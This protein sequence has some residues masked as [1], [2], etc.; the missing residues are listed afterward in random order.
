[1]EELATVYAR[2]LHEAAQDADRFDVVRE[3]IGQLADA[4][5]SDR[6]LQVFLFSPYFSSEEKKQGLRK[7]VSDADDLVANFLELLVENHRMP[8]LF[9]I[10]REL[11]R[12]W[13]EEHRMLP[14]E[15]TS[16]VELDEQVVK[17]IG[18]RIGEQTGRTVELTAQVD[19]DVLGGLVVRVGNTV[20]DA[21][22][23]HRLEQLRKQV[24]RP[25]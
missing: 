3:Q 8:A 9:R 11:D 20:L 14:V 25:A 17:R 4:L 19:P 21:S 18:D 16:A 13:D 15:I 1:M 24:S 7:A 6:D 23:R 2:S 10:R 12:L 22:I 5:E